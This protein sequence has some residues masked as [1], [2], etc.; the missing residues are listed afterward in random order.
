MKERLDFT[1]SPRHSNALFSLLTFLNQQVRKLT[2]L[3]M[4]GYNVSWASFAIV[5]VMSQSR[6]AH[7]RIGYQAANQVSVSPVSSHWLKAP[8]A[9]ASAGAL[10]ST[11]Y[12]ISFWVQQQQYK[13]H[14]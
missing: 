13:K 7:K 8:A 4:I 10:C 6:F 5:E 9:S 14:K 3:Q 1:R 2:Y 12:A 11:V